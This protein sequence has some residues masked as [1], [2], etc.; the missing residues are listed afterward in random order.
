MGKL[1]KKFLS[2]LQ[3]LN[4]MILGKELYSKNKVLIFAFVFL[5]VVAFFSHS[6][7]KTFHLGI[8][9]VYA[10][11]IVRTITVPFTDFAATLPFGNFFNS[12]RKM[13]LTLLQLEENHHWED[14]YY[15]DAKDEEAF[16]AI[17]RANTES[18][19]NKI[20][21]LPE[22]NTVDAKTFSSQ[23]LINLQKKET[24]S[25]DLLVVKYDYTKEKPLRILFAG[26]SQ[27]QSL[28]EGFKRNIGT[29]SA[30]DVTDLAVVSSGFVRTDYYNWSAKLTNLL[31]EA[32]NEGRAYD[33]VVLLLGMN[34][35]QNFFDGNG[36]LF[37]RGTKEWDA[38]YIEKIKNVMNVLET[39]VKKIYWLGLPIVRSPALRSEVNHVEAIQIKALK[40]LDDTKVKRISLRAIV[41]GENASYTETLQTTNG[42]R[43]TFMKEDGTHFTLAGSSFLMGEVQKYFYF[44]FNIKR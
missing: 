6:K 40:F 42:K 18:T 20:H 25:N 29:E 7:I 15:G 43:I 23:D 33:A 28:A 34:D 17:L 27:M 4:R 26:D 3:V 10:K 16:T 2:F 32:E 14:L 39:S 37:K 11:N 35:Y 12:S 13:L 31:S 38:A 36:K 41:S 30:F 1:G 8:K 5:S 19:Q 22:A 21:S 24:Q 44:D 9:N